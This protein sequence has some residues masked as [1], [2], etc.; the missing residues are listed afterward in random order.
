MVQLIVRIVAININMN[1]KLLKIQ[2]E[3]E[4]QYLLDKYRAS[5]E[6]IGQ[7]ELAIKFYATPEAQGLEGANHAKDQSL[8]AEHVLRIKVAERNF[9]EHL[10]DG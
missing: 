3:V 5:L 9:Y 7:C 6:M 4:E 10:L 8:K 2:K 1:K